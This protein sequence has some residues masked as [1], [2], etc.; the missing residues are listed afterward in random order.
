MPPERLFKWVSAYI[1]VWFPVDTAL[2]SVL[3]RIPRL[4]PMLAGLIPIPC[5]NHL[6][7]GLSYRQRLEWAVL[8]TFDALGAK[9][10]RPMTRRE[11]ESMVGGAYRAIEVLY[12]AN[13][14]VAN[15]A[16]N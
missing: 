14:V 7:M 10:D 15:V 11:V 2:K 8:N 9:Y 16:R 6:R 12:G 5:W 4:G 13:G 3:F 1:P